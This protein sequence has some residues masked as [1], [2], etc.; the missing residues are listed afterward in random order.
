MVRNP[1]SGAIMEKERAK[2]ILRLARP[3]FLVPGIMLY[4]LGALVAAAQG[5][6]LD[7]QKFLFGYAIFLFAHASVPF[8]ND[9]FDRESDRFAEQ[10]AFSGGSGVLVQHPEMAPLAL[11]FALFLVGASILTAAAFTM[12]YSYP[13]WF[14]IF[15][16]LGGLI[17]WFYTAP[18]LRLAYRGLGEASTVIASGFV[19]PGLGYLV[20]FGTI[21]LWF[22]LL[23]LPLMCYALYFILTVELPDVEADRLSG[24]INVMVRRG[25]AV[26]YKLSLAACLAATIAFLTLSLTGVMGTEINFWLLTLLSSIPLII[27]AIGFLRKPSNK[28]GIVR[29]VKLNF[30]GMM[31]FLAIVDV[32]LLVQVI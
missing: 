20:V 17:G 24:K 25:R 11:K 26:G 16:V 3:R 4:T 21:D 19:M 13:L 28:A 9:Y 32:M 2:L 15:A 14:F 18:P 30:A 27:A 31:T 5:M 29:Q 8:S 10:T 12:F 22:V 6:A 1:F 7:L 23:S